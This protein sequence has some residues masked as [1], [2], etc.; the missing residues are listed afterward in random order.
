MGT[1]G[2][3]MSG[4]LKEED[5]WGRALRG[6][7]L[8]GDDHAVL[9]LRVLR[10]ALKGLKGSDLSGD[11]PA[12]LPLRVSRRPTCP[13]STTILQSPKFK[14]HSPKVHQRRRMRGGWG[15]G[16][17]FFFCTR[18]DTKPHLH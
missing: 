13:R 9:P 18:C 8:S 3:R 15:G 12:V 6:S 5:E 17:F 14:V 4:D 2:R 16:G 10:A 7:D 11:D 1:L